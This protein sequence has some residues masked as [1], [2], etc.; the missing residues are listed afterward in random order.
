MINEMKH[1]HFV[2]DSF[3]VLHLVNTL[4]KQEDDW[5]TNFKNTFVM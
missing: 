4:A 1:A 5:V 3:T 2:R